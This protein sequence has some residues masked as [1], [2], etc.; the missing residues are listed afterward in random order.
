MMLRTLCYCL[1]ACLLATGCR[2]SYHAF[3]SNYTYRSPAGQP[4]YAVLDNWAAHPYKQ[5]PADSV[6]R[7]LRAAYHPDSTVD[8][9]FIHPTTYTDREKPFGWNGPVDDGELNAKTDYTT[10][11]FQASIFNVAGRVFAPRY[12]QANLAAYY[13]ITPDD[14][15]HARQAFEEAYQDVKAAFNY[16]MLRLNRGHPIIIASHSQGTTHA[17]R[18]LKEFFDGKALQ[19]KLVAAYLVGMVLEPDYFTTLSPCQ[20]PLQTGC[21]TGWRTFKNGYVP[22]FIQ[23]ETFQSV[24]TNP[25]SWDATVP[26]AGREQNRGGV[27]L[28][29]NKVMPGVA[30]AGVHK[31]LLWSI[32]P[33]FFGNLFLRSRNY[34]V[35]DMNLYYTSI[36]QNA[37]QRVAAYKNK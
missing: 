13:P 6:P 37:A 12:R 15:A 23:K 21:Y 35:A 33:R 32:K 19:S 30:D 9:F 22:P 10:I 2:K 7:P 25:L 4:D 36:R 29:F 17:K 27:L 14:T 3:A 26:Y 1:L 8:V 24:V 31:G 20:T 16:Y 28:N 18:L 5:D 11:L 34:H